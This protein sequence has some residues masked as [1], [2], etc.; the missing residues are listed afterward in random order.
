MAWQTEHT[1]AHKVSNIS[2]NYRQL[3]EAGVE[4]VVYSRDKHTIGCPVPDKHP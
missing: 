3:R 1:K 2:K 4:K